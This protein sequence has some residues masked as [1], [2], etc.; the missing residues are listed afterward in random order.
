MQKE[1]VTIEVSPEVATRIRDAS[2]QERE[3][4]EVLLNGWM[5]GQDFDRDTAELRTLMDEIGGQ[6][7][8]RGLSPEV[9]ADIL[10][11]K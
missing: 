9:L 10:G 6:A 3:S 1:K 4:L 2:P 8:A 7:T 5:R 11:E